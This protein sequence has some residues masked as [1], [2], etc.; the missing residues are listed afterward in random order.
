MNRSQLEVVKADARISYIFSLLAT[1]WSIILGTVVVVSSRGD[2]SITNV[3]PYLVFMIFGLALIYNSYRSTINKITKKVDWFGQRWTFE[4][5][6]PDSMR[7]HPLRWHSTDHSAWA[8]MDAPTT[9]LSL[10]PTKESGICL[11]LKQDSSQIPY[12]SWAVLFV[13]IPV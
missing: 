4:W 1:V 3:W 7:T 8:F 2:I 5:E 12:W 10:P 13:Q 11:G 9:G 6:V